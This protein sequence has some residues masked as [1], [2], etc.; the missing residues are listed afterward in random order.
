MRRAST[1]LA[2]LGLAVL[3]LPAAASAA[4]AVTLKVKAVPIPGF[5]GTGNILGAG[6]DIE[7]QYTVKGTEYGGFPPPLTG[8]TFDSPAGVK[9]ISKGF[10]T[11]PL[12]ALKTSGPA[13]CPKKSI[14]SPIGEALGVVSFGNE[15]VEEKA[16]L[17]AFFAP[18]GGLSFY[19]AGSTPVSL[20]FVST[21]H[22]IN[23]GS[24]FGPK[25]IAEVPV[26]ETVPDAPDASVLSFKVRVGAAYKKGKK[27]VSYINLP[28]KCPKGGFPVK[29][30]LQYLGGTSSIAAYKVP[31]PKGGKQK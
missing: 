30:E 10:V 20:E 9:L 26:I 21:A 17:Q 7:A 19:V 28:K 4:P 15:R 12:A 8:V 23:P 29:S 24:G 13:G 18:G 22:F 2:L 1:C 11:C 27:T 6:A 3:G 16:S 25:L 14:A 5:P 31:C